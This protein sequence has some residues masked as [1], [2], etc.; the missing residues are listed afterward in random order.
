MD[1]QYGLHPSLVLV[2]F[3]NNYE[4]VHWVLLNGLSCIA[5]PAMIT[6]IIK[7]YVRCDVV[8]CSKFYLA[9]RSIVTSETPKIEWRAKAMLFCINGC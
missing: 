2:A 6:C 7:F 1:G 4:N 8:V 5:A 9:V 3:D